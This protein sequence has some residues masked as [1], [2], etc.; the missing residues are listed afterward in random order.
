ME[1]ITRK[2]NITKVDGSPVDESAEY[3][4]LRLD[5]KGDAKHVEAGRKAML[6][7]ARE[8]G[9]E[10]PT[11]AK[12]IRDRYAEKVTETVRGVSTEDL[13]KKQEEADKASEKSGNTDDIFKTDT[14]KG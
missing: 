2:Y 8:I 4:V 1:G 12:D 14:F 13:K 3:F 9:E 11:L 10:N 7:Y 5:D 6:T